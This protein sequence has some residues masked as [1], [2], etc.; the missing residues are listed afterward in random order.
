MWRGSDLVGVKRHWAEK[1]GAIHNDELKAGVAKLDSREWPPTLPEFLKLCRPDVESVK[2][3][4]EAV[5]G[6]EARNKGETGNWSHP[7]IFHAAVRVGSFDLLQQSFASVRP[8]W[9]RALADELL[10][11][12]WPAIESPA[13]QLESNGPSQASRQAAAAML[14][15]LEATGITKRSNASIDH[16]KWALDILGRAERGDTTLT[17]LQVHFAKEAMGA[18]G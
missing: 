5:A 18:H 4:Y 6:M 9:E 2:A 15:H 1:L 8:R 13:L 12:E 17:P 10:K 7:A 16:R 11:S 14:R 3:Y